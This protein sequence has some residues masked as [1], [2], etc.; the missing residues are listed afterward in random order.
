MKAT[1]QE[2][3]R[4]EPTVF[5]AVRRYRF[6]VLAITLV[7]AGAALAYTF[8]RPPLYS[9]HATVTVPL[10]LISQGQSSDQYLDSQ[11]LLLQSQDVAQRAVRIA[12]AALA[13]GVLAE[14]DFSGDRKSVEITPP[15][16]SS[17]SYGSSLV[18]VSFT[19]P[20]AKVAQVGANALLRAFDDVR[21]AAIKA[22]GEATIAGIEKAL[23]DA[24]TQDQQKELLKQRTQA[25]VNLQVDLSRH[26]TVAWAL[27]PQRPIN[28]NM[29]KSVA[30]GLLLGL[31]LGSAAAFARASRRKTFDNRLEPAGL[32]DAPLIGEIGTTAAEHRWVGKGA[33][34][35]SLAM[36]TD[37]HSALAEAFRFTAGSVERIRAARG[38]GLSL[39]FVSTAAAGEMSSIVANL[40]V[41]MAESGTRVLA[42]DAGAGDGHLTAFLLPDGRASDGFEQV[43]S[44]RKA[45]ADCI[46]PSPQH[47][48]VF[49]LGSGPEAP[50]KPTGAAYSKAVEKLLADAK[51]SFDVILIDGPAMLRV[52]DA[53]ELVDASDAVIVVIG[54]DEPIGDHLEMVNRLDL[55][56]TEVVG[57]V[58]RPAPMRHRFR[59]GSS[60]RS[61]RKTGSTAF[62]DPMPVKGSGR[63]PPFPGFEGAQPLESDSHPSPVPRARR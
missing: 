35:H 27:E 1:A 59:G 57:Y 46:Q 15:E 49:V 33:A 43:L 48:R 44:G 38:S 25:L 62:T 5:G 41:A 16:G 47:K 31:L 53:M 20:S 42:V 8:V 55:I 7:T 51:A 40:A 26:P 54:A 19:W 29:T 17:G 2:Q 23:R 63:R 50:D 52:A 14:R 11:V 12:N 56:E 3:L 6:M 21:S 18:A 4:L 32:Y 13:G 9:A 24:R 39:A 10:P 60:T 45:A 22:Q 37:P 36:N 58:Y 28:D 34:S 61:A 30:I